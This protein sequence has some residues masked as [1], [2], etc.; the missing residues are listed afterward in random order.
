MAARGGDVDLVSRGYRPWPLDRDAGVMGHSGAPARTGVPLE[1]LG[2]VPGET[3][4][5]LSCCHGS[6]L[7]LILGL[8]PVLA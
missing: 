5:P 2:T 4:G 1:G 6:E 3:L 7:P 8:L